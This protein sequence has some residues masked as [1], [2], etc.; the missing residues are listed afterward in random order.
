MLIRFE[1]RIKDTQEHLERSSLEASIN[2]GFADDGQEESGLN[3]ADSCVVW[4]RHQSV[5]TKA[6]LSWRVGGQPLKNMSLL[7]NT[8]DATSVS[9]PCASLFSVPWKQFPSS[10]VLQVQQVSVFV[11]FPYL[12]DLL[13]RW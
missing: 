7:F 12:Q 2:Q 1:T 6:D 5:L 10:S 8:T 13:S 11:F 9:Q 4:T 3:S